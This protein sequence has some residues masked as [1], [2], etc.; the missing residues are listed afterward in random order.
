MRCTRC[1]LELAFDN[2]SVESHKHEL[3]QTDANNQGDRASK[4]S[5]LT[6][7]VRCVSVCLCQENDRENGRT[8]NAYVGSVTFFQ[9]FIYKL[10]FML[11]RFAFR[12]KIGTRTFAN[13]S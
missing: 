2:N 1:L 3:K 12:F 8:N 7:C 11:C 13:S 5:V 4:N 9:L 6:V 10:Y